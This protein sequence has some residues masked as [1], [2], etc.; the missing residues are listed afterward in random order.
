MDSSEPIQ[1]MQ[2]VESI[3]PT[4]DPS[5]MEGE[6]SIVASPVTVEHSVESATITIP[7]AVTT[8]TAPAQVEEATEI[9]QLFF[10]RANP[11]NSEESLTT[12]FAQCGEVEELILFKDRST[13][14]SKGCGFVKFSTRAAA[15]AAIDSLDQKHTM[16][17]ARDTLSVKWADPELQ[18]KRKKRSR[19]D[20][21][22]PDNKQLFFGRASKSA[23]EKEIEEMFSKYGSVKEVVIFREKGGGS[24]GCGFVT[25]ET[26][27]EAEMARTSLD[28]S[29]PMP[30]MTDTFSCQWADPQLRERTKARA[31]GFQPHGAYPQGGYPGAYTHQHPGYPQPGYPYQPP[32]QGY[33]D[34]YGYQ[35]G[36]QDPYNQY[37]AHQH[38]A[39]TQPAGPQ[40]AGPPADNHQLYVGG[41]PHNVG[42]DELSALMARCGTIKQIK[43][44][45]DKATN[46]H[47]GAAF[48]TYTSRPE[49]E[50]AIA[51]FHQTHTLSGNNKPMIVKF[52]DRGQYTGAPAPGTTAPPAAAWAP[53]PYVAPHAPTPYQA[54]YGQ[55]E[56]PYNGGWAPQPAA[57]G[58]WSY[59]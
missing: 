4:A 42:E 36:Y 13:Q 58:Q 21:G 46:T 5:S 11:M 37:G 48:C 25:L 33:Y 15:Q 27:A 7:E 50:A 16:E 23:D 9:R 10:A 32:P 57:Y 38:G 56:A 24:K 8:E 44:L 3:E 14:G 35:Y 43:V 6:E 51:A 26:R 41:V 20:F 31:A 54:P 55:Y 1:E 40:P 59:Q 49:A 29:A 18:D 45:R 39:Y 22:D 17:G 28:G 30:G 2:A 47:K 19:D 52:A 34:G 12:V 53:P